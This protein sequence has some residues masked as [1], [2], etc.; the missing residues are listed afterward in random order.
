MKRRI[1]AL[2]LCGLMV[3]SV[4]FSLT[5]PQAQAKAG[6]FNDLGKQLAKVYDQLV[7]DP[8]GMSDV[9]SAKAKLANLSR[10]PN[11]APW[12]DVFAIVLTN[13]VTTRLGGEA[14]AK[15]KVIDFICD[16]GDVYYSDETNNL[17][18][19]MKQFIR[20]HAYTI[21]ALFGSDVTIDDLCNYLLAAIGE[22][23]DSILGNISVS[24]ICSLGSG[25]Y[26]VIRY[27]MVTFIRGALV[28]AATGQYSTFLDKLGAIGLSIDKLF[29][30][31]NLITA[32]VDPSHSGESA[33]MK[34]YVRSETHFVKDGKEWDKD[35]NLKA[36]DTMPLEL[37]VLGW[38][39]GKHWFLFEV[40]D[41][42]VATV[43]N[44][45][46]IL[47]GVA[48]GKTTLRCYVS[49]T[50]WVYQGTVHVTGG[51]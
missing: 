32:E 34:A 3:F 10:D 1:I 22:M 37:T 38:P 46:D 30:A 21:T 5:P 17:R 13:Q 50:S 4:T 15:E 33:L 31:K 49:N 44:F 51:K 36:G 39:L 28:R 43:N 45:T 26:N 19:S 14:A 18:K 42:G 41:A 11:S 9:A 25:N 8:N 40:D 24:G 12:P 47:T 2:M 35:I 7:F 27:G 6:A 29:E 23:P 16:F 20:Q 48:N